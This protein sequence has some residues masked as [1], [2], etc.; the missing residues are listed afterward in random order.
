MALSSAGML[1]PVGTHDDESR[2][3]EYK[4]NMVQTLK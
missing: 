4:E 1:V 3:V 2:C